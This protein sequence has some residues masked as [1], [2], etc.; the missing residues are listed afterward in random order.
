[1]LQSRLGIGI[2][3]ELWMLGFLY[4]A[5]FNCW[6]L[7]SSYF[8]IELTVDHCLVECSLK[9]SVVRLACVVRELT[10]GKVV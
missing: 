6:L 1:M 8:I 10:T 5:G 7:Y 3:M 9:Y 4:R 2:C